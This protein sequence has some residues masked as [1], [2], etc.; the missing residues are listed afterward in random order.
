MTAGAGAA[1]IA[2]ATAK[3]A[4]I[5]GRLTMSERTAMINHTAD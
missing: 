5:A 4:A 2:G 1:R 3:I